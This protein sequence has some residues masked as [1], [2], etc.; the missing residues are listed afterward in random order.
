MNGQEWARY[1]CTWDGPESGV[2]NISLSEP[3]GLHSGIWQVAVYVNDVPAL[4]EQIEV[5]GDWAYWSPPGVFNTCY[6][7]R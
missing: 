1:E 4:L 3:N 6:G 7:Y 2:D 5:E